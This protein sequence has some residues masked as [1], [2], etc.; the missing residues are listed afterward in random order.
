MEK[1]S[2]RYVHRTF[3][4]Q[5]GKI[6]FQVQHFNG[7]INSQSKQFIRVEK[8]QEI[9]RKQDKEI[10]LEG[11]KQ[12][13]P[14]SNLIS[15][16]NF[17]YVSIKTEKHELLRMIYVFFAARFIAALSFMRFFFIVKH[18]LMQILNRKI[19]DERKQAR[20]GFRP[21]SAI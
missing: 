2:S 16:N 9:V 13:F 15:G 7:T 11:P 5:S 10:C 14:H 6:F 21:S 19:E 1:Y 20:K 3:F 4:S 12:F 18:S 8:R 17:Y